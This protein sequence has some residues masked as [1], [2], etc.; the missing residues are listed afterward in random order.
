M[1][2]LEHWQYRF[3]PTRSTIC[4]VLR[5]GEVRWIG[6]DLL[7]AAGA[8]L[9]SGALAEFGAQPGHDQPA[10]HRQLAFAYPLEDALQL[11]ADF[12]LDERLR[13]HLAE[14]VRF[15]HTGITQVLSVQPAAALRP[16]AVLPGV[17]AAAAL[18]PADRTWSIRE[19]ARVLDR[20]P[21]I[22]IG[23]Q[24]LFDWLHLHG[25]IN[26]LTHGWE[27]S[28]LMVNFG[29]AITRHDR[30]PGQKDL[31][32]NVRLTDLG[33][34]ALHERLGGVAALTLTTTQLTLV[35]E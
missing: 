26:H 31:Y 15:S 30:I 16:V 22:S 10:E 21:A 5:D 12:A 33:L 3:T 13:E 35:E 20:D 27:A 23:Q 19:A 9:T 29:W 24:A 6:R 18:T 17:D 7:A 14:L 8:D 4:A 2:E 34:Q 32:P 1:G 25:W 28:Q 11:V